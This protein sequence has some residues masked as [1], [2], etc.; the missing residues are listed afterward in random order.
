VLYERFDFTLCSHA[1]L[2]YLF[3]VTSI[4]VRQNGSYLTGLSF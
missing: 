3:Q 2:C 1:L 4:R